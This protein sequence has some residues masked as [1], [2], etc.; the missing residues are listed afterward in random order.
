M[1]LPHILENII[2][3]VSKKEE[4]VL[5]IDIG[6]S[7]IKIVQLKK[8][9]GRAFLETYGEVALGPYADVDVGR[10]V[11]LPNDV[12]S[13]ALKDVIRESRK[14]IVPE[15][16]GRSLLSGIVIPL[17]SSLITVANIPNLSDKNFDQIVAIEARKYIPVSMSEISLDWQILPDYQN[18][19]SVVADEGVNKNLEGNVSLGLKPSVEAQ[20]LGKKNSKVLIVAVHTDVI[21]RTRELF[22]RSGLK[23]KFIEVEAFSSVRSCINNR[24]DA[25]L[26]VDH[27][28]SATKV[29]IVDEGVVRI[30]HTISV[31][32]QDFTLAIS[33]ALN[34]SVAEAESIKRESGVSVARGGVDV[35]KIME[36]S[37]SYMVSEVDRLASEYERNNNRVVSEIVLSGGGINLK[38]LPQLFEKSLKYPIRIANP[39]SA[40]DTPAFLEEVL[41]E[42]GPSFAVAIGAG[43]RALSSE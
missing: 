25:F 34:I 36:G 27:G 35:G 20:N 6:G 41:K 18:V 11:R 2:G 12:L 28:A 19:S 38:G 30:S 22:L 13:V 17:S 4:S 21:S 40:I 31:G 33:R 43:I 16:D 1:N 8:K 5:G 32:S 29:Y 9:D 23:E 7:A 10:A 37:L 24:M 39:F 3:I 14:D 26:I 42:V 15:D